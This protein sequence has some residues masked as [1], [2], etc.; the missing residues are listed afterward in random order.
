MDQGDSEFANGD[1]MKPTTREIGPLRDMVKQEVSKEI[2]K[3]RSELKLQTLKEELQQ[4]DKRLDQSMWLVGTQYNAIM[5]LIAILGLVGLIFG[6][7]QYLAAEELKKIRGDVDNYMKDKIDSFLYEKKAADI[8][9]NLSYYL[10]N[11]S[12]I[13]DRDG[14]KFT[15]IRNSQKLS[16]ENYKKIVSKLETLLRHADTSRDSFQKLVALV[17]VSSKLE[18][19]DYLDS[20]FEKV[21]DLETLKSIAPDFDQFEVSSLPRAIIQYC[22]Q[23]VNKYEEL[24]ISL[25]EIEIQAPKELGIHMSY[26]L[27]NKYESEKISKKIFELFEA[28]P[29]RL[30]NMANDKK[31]I[32]YFLA[33]DW[34][35][36][37][38]AE[39]VIRDSGKLMDKASIGKKVNMREREQS[40]L[41]SEW[42]K[43]TDALE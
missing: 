21:T 19:S 34:G 39:G 35:S 17:D 2:E 22:L 33:N 23:N 28:I 16:E 25:L 40:Y 27:E 6:V 9:L 30:N 24:I 1:I 7:K 14:S 37:I 42:K 43:R 5:F 29:N 8:A 13:S 18:S 20:F 26:Y 32:D 12:Y 3:Y 10:D 11:D 15:I 41:S 31:S 4:K 38:T 36:I